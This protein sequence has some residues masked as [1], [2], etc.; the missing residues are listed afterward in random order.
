VPEQ[1]AADARA[2]P[3]YCERLI[4]R[5]PAGRVRPFVAPLAPF[6]DPGSRAFEDPSL[7]YHRFCTSLDDHRRAF[8]HDRWDQILSYDSGAMTRR[9]IVAATYD[10]A[11]ALN[12]IKRRH[13]LIDNATFLGVAE[14]L[15]AARQLFEHSDDP[16]ALTHAVLQLANHGTMF[17]DDELKWP[18]PGRFR[19]GAALLRGLA[20]GLLREIGH[21][22]ARLTGRYDA[23]RITGHTS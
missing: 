11:A 10:V 13:R 9:E 12:D 18:A 19:V 21:T 5:S 20:S 14:R 16:S 7:D 3:E 15:Y 23:A 6:L 2:I 8:L 1:R 4:A 22:V 17:G